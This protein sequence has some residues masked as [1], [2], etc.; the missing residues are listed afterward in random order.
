MCED[1]PKMHGWTQ[2]SPHPRPFVSGHS[3]PW[4]FT[5][6]T[7]LHK[8]KSL[9]SNVSFQVGLIPFYF[10]GLVEHFVFKGIIDRFKGMNIIHHKMYFSIFEVHLF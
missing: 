10:K 2:L 6:Y 5:L 4:E 9:V 1:I 3:P 7:L 8:I